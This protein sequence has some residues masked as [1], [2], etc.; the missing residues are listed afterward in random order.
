MDKK[1]GVYICTGCGIGDIVDIEALSGVVSGEMKMSCK[2]HP[3]LCGAEGRAIIEK[4]TS[5]GSNSVVIGACSP[6]VVA[7]E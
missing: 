1:L 5:E 7:T 3:F 2:T 4:D 6:R